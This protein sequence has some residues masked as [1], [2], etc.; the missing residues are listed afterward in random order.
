M[1][2]GDA[3]PSALWALTYFDYRQNQLKAF[4]IDKGGFYREE[5]IARERKNKRRADYYY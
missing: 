2:K 4:F 1:V 3:L 5:P